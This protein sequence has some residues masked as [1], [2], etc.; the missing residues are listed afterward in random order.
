MVGETGAGKTTAVQLAAAALGRPLHTV[1]LHAHTDA[2]DLLGGLRPV[3]GR[4]AAAAAAARAAALGAFEAAAAL[5]ADCGSSVAD[6][7]AEGAHSPTVAPSGAATFSAAA[8]VAAPAQWGA[9]A[10]LIGAGAAA[11][12]AGPSAPLTALHRWLAAAQ[13][14]AAGATQPA[15][16]EPSSDQSAGAAAASEAAAAA[17]AGAASDDEAASVAAALLASAEKLLSALL[18][19]SDSLEA[20]ASSAA[21]PGVGSEEAAAAAA[22]A[23]AAGGGAEDDGSGSTS[24]DGLG[25]ADD[26][27]LRRSK[28]IRKASA[29]AADQASDGGSAL[30]GVTSATATGPSAAAATS[31]A[32]AAASAT[33]T[34]A[35][36]ATA[37]LPALLEAVSRLRSRLSDAA[38]LMS[39]SKA[40]FDWQDGPVTAAMRDGGICLLDEVSLADDAV[41]ER[42][43][44]LLETGRTITLPEMPGKNAGTAGAT[45]VA[46]P[47]FRIVATMNPGGDV[48]KRELSPAL[49][50]RLTEIWVPP[51]TT[52]DDV[53]AVVADMCHDA[54]MAAARRFLKASPRPAP[55]FQSALKD[56]MA[57]LAPAIADLFGWFWAHASGG[58]LDGGRTHP[59]SSGD[60]SGNGRGSG[61]GRAVDSG[62]ASRDDASSRRALSGGATLVFTLRDASAWAAFA[63]SAMAQQL[64][65]DGEVGASAGSAGASDA[66]CSVG[67]GPGEAAG[68]GLRL[69]LLDGLGLGTG[70]GSGYAAPEEDSDSS[71]GDSD[72]DD[73]PD[74][75]ADA[76]AELYAREARRS[77]RRSATHR[78]DRMAELRQAAMDRLALALP[79]A[80]RSGVEQSGRILAGRCGAGQA[81]SAAAAR[82]GGA[83]SASTPTT[84][85]AAAIGGAA[86]GASAAAGAAITFANKSRPVFGI[87][88]FLIP[89]DPLAGARDSSSLGFALDAPTPRSNL[90]RLLAALALRRPVLLEGSPGAGKSSIVAALARGAGKRL[91]R[92][93]LSEQSDVSDLF[94][95]D[96]PAPEQ[97]HVAPGHSPVAASVGDASSPSSSSAPAQADADGGSGSMRFRWVDGPLLA[98]VRRG[99]WL[100]L[101]EL[102]LA[103]QPVLEGLNAIL[104]H[105][106]AVFIPETGETV[107]IDEPGSPGSV[108]PAGGFRVF[109]TQNPVS[110]GGGRRGL[111]KSLLNRFVKITVHELTGRDIRAIARSPDSGREG[112]ALPASALLGAPGVAVPAGAASRGRRQRRAAALAAAASEAALLSPLCRGFAVEGGPFEFNLRDVQR[113][114][115]VVSDA[116][117]RAQAAAGAVGLTPL[118]RAATLRAAVPAGASLLFVA[119][120]RSATD[121]SL[122]GE[123]FARWF[124]TLPRPTDLPV[125]TARVASS[126]AAGLQSHGPGPS[127]AQQSLIAPERVS[128]VVSLLVAASLG[129]PAL[130]LGPAGGPQLDV[131]SDAALLAGR[132]LGRVELGPTTDAGDLVG[133]YEQSDAVSDAVDAA[134]ALANAANR[135]AS[136]V[137][138]TA[139]EADVSAFKVAAELL[140]SS[141]SLKDLATAVSLGLPL[142]PVQQ[143]QHQQQQRPDAEAVTHPTAQASMDDAAASADDAALLAARAPG[144]VSAANA[145]AARVSSA[146]L[147][148]TAIA[149]LAACAADVSAAVASLSSAMRD[150]SAVSSASTAG[151]KAV[152]AQSADAVAYLRTAADRCA[153]GSGPGGFRWRDGPVTRAVS[154]GSWLCLS[155]AASAPAAVL[156]RLNAVLE[157][158]GELVVS[159]CAVASAPSKPSPQRAVSAAASEQDGAGAT[160][161]AAADTVRRIKPAAGFWAVLC[162]DVG[163]DPALTTGLRIPSALQRLAGGRAVSSRGS[164]SSLSTASLSRAMRNRCLEIWVGPVSSGSSGR[165]AAPEHRVVVGR[166]LALP[167]WASTSVASAATST[168]WPDRSGLGGSEA[169]LLAAALAV[170]PAVA[171]APAGAASA[172][173]GR[174]VV[175]PWPDTALALGMASAHAGSAGS[176]SSLTVAR[177]VAQFAASLM[178][179]PLSGSLSIGGGSAVAA[180]SL[181]AALLGGSGAWLAL[182]NAQ[183][184]PSVPATAALRVGLAELAAPLAELAVKPL[185]P[186]SASAAFAASHAPAGALAAAAAAVRAAV[187][188]LPDSAEPAL[189]AV[190]AA[191]PADAGRESAGSAPAAAMRVVAAALAATEETHPADASIAA[192]LRA[193]AAAA[194]AAAGAGSAGRAAAA[195][196]LASIGVPTAL[197]RSLNDAEQRGADPMVCL[198]SQLMTSSHSGGHHGEVGP[199]LAA[200][201]GVRA[202]TVLLAAAELTAARCQGGSA[203][204]LRAVASMGAPQRASR[205]A[206]SVPLVDAA[207]TEPVAATALAA[208]AAEVFAA[209]CQAAS[210]VAEARPG[211]QAHPEAQPEAQTGVDGEALRKLLRAAS[212]AAASLGAVAAAGRTTLRPPAETVNRVTSIGRS[213]L[214]VAQLVMSVQTAVTGVVAFL[215]ASPAAGSA[216]PSPGHGAGHAAGGS[217]LLSDSTMSLIPEV[218]AALANASSAVAAAATAASRLA[219][220]LGVVAAG[221]AEATGMGSVIRR[222]VAPA[223]ADECWSHMASG[224]VATVSGVEVARIQL[225]NR[226]STSD[227]DTTEAEASLDVAEH[228]AK[229]TVSRVAAA[230]G[231]QSLPLLWRAAVASG[232][233]YVV[234]SAATAAAGETMQSSADASG[235]ADEA[236]AAVGDVSQR[237]RGQAIQLGEASWWPGALVSASTSSSFDGASTSPQSRVDAERRRVALE[238]AGRAALVSIIG[239]TAALAAAAGAAGG[240]TVGAGVRAGSLTG[241][242]SGGGSGAAYR[243]DARALDQLARDAAVLKAAASDANAAADSLLTASGVPRSALPPGVDA[244]RAILTTP[245][246]AAAEYGSGACSGSGRGIGEEADDEEAQAGADDADEEDEASAAAPAGGSAFG[247]ASS[248]GSTVVLSVSE[249]LPAALSV[250]SAVPSEVLAAL[251][252]AEA[253]S[254]SEATSAGQRAGWGVVTSAE[255]RWRDAARQAVSDAESLVAD[256]LAAGAAA[257]NDWLPS[258]RSVALWGHITALSITSTSAAHPAAAAGTPAAGPASA[259]ASAGRSTG[260]TTAG[261]RGPDAP[262]ADAAGTVASLLHE[263]VSALPLSD[264]TAVG[265]MSASSTVKRAG[266]ALRR[267]VECSRAGVGV[268]SLAAALGSAMPTEG[269]ADVHGIRAVAEATVASAATVLSSPSGLGGASVGRSS[270][271]ADAASL[272]SALVSL[273]AS[274]RRALVV[275]AAGADARRRAAAALAAAGAA[276]AAGGSG[277]GLAEAALAVAASRVMVVSVAKEAAARLRGRAAVSGA[278]M[279]DAASLLLPTQGWSSAEA[280]AAGG[281]GVWTKAAE[282]GSALGSA[283]ASRQS[284]LLGG[285]ASAAS[286]SRALSAAAAA[287]AA[288]GGFALA[289]AAADVTSAV[290]GSAAVYT[291]VRSLAAR[292]ALADAALASLIWLSDTSSTATHEQAS[293]PGR[294]TSG[295]SYR[296]AAVGKARIALSDAATLAA[297]LAAAAAATAASAESSGE[298]GVLARLAAALRHASASASVAS[299]QSSL[300]H[301]QAS[302]GAVGT[303]TLTPAQWASTT[304]AAVTVVTDAALALPMGAASS[305]AAALE[306]ASTLASALTAASEAGS[307]SRTPPSTAWLL[308]TAAAVS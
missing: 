122:V 154:H 63:A 183:A 266:A 265:G 70:M 26:G 282:V 303:E 285:G 57:E 257:A 272:L 129:W 72:A 91:V 267:L 298:A 158:G 34:A 69:C 278:L 214:S 308:A 18:T 177:R 77:A 234:G 207:A 216:G 31:A 32:A 253:A 103:P 35:A 58:R 109:A 180:A 279:S 60:G 167:A 188:D 36:S 237:R 268:A 47:S 8:A 155:H 126:L 165:A 133:Q 40:L 106:G 90:T 66:R 15:A 121:R 185:G 153:A 271:Q 273:T 193:A 195:S 51:L 163:S 83:G 187:S 118:R 92:V 20:A 274:L 161:S 249:W 300:D 156:D 100:L 81:A 12:E 125:P 116:L 145:A 297:G 130:V 296:R 25:S 222:T 295:D 198:Q 101:D 96:L 107:T 152:I 49:R 117:A 99:D 178:S 204:A 182:L 262:A 52:A 169:R 192:L 113:W 284:R 1:S 10:A 277:G 304:Q 245:S 80:W 67:L 203:E 37:A 241:G 137:A 247:S 13:A 150:A 29:D 164:G 260:H 65:S 175:S 17:I 218:R 206:D 248:S 289:A 76:D 95:A 44:S 28:R 166:P 194:V 23:A 148:A 227:M 294:E 179:S 22:D 258:D 306:R 2:A 301:G 168:T 102:N 119:R 4:A 255:A 73:A 127:T 290:P 24:S 50:S 307:A 123:M 97:Q 280:A 170:A 211:M 202:A 232:L 48:G 39:R 199:G 112:T 244:R 220:A 210:S 138:G 132:A 238:A 190:L 251:S 205:T 287:A 42:L 82:N 226:A 131:V 288:G 56:R 45:L 184:T 9:V 108:S 263:A 191:L 189:S 30:E 254:L 141:T 200:T 229:A 176:E 59:G 68:A 21:V 75:G 61:S 89:A 221:R 53:R 38:S 233:R 41:L 14:A 225:R 98:A 139:G 276:A 286:S 215:V 124:P 142:P 302:A 114:K 208:A 128:H 151:I 120:L 228:L 115:A 293:L 104:D 62:S 94:G 111:P 160:H 162:A 135:A 269:L 246:Q 252:D 250:A 230:L 136:V 74:A 5:Q 236:A 16:S 231:S 239:S 212:A 147:A 46:H 235:D 209:A 78:H 305:A 186:L 270:A 71:A 223:V 105:R 3:R 33:A 149:R 181:I 197:A 240:A 86:A 213:S 79:P 6:A 173:A 143:K 275:S 256:V 146:E 88:P 55:H 93:N 140:Q 64:A 27:G 19:L 157:P 264:A 43:N 281:D 219:A 134:I 11:G 217:A 85:A 144:A 259:A 84:T 172:P 196:A 159:E 291:P 110:Q 7:A 242:R 292:A 201:A 174:I 54:A 299:P 261:T 283:A 224:T 171:V 243:F 87:A